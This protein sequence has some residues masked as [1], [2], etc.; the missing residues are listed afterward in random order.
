M[1]P[2]FVHLVP[3]LLTG[4]GVALLH[5]AI[6]THWLPFVLAARAQKWTLVKT[7][8]ITLLGSFAH[9]IFTAGLGL[10]VLSFGTSLFEHYESW[11][12]SIAGSALIVFG[13][14]IIYQQKFGGGHS[15]FLLHRHDHKFCKF[16]STDS[17][18]TSV[19]GRR[20]DRVA[21]L[22]LIGALFLSPCEVILPIYLS[23]VEFGWYGFFSL[24]AALA[25]ATSLGMISL[26]TLTMFG[27]VKFQFRQLERIEIL[28]VALLICLLGVSII[29]F[30]H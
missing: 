7:L 10:I 21:V 26:V 5:S 29:F 9:A 25:I 12:H 6:P 30:G 19:E 1:T 18:Q 27:L 20:S 15:H 13:L 22:A 3:I 14:Y 28:G 24:S 16:D 8:T 17:I 23:A 11:F 4:F 2:S